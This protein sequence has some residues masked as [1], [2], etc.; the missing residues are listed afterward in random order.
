[1]KSSCMMSVVFGQVLERLPHKKEALLEVGRSFHRFSLRSKA[2]AA[3]SPCST[4]KASPADEAAAA[5]RTGFDCEVPLASQEPRGRPLKAAMAMAAALHAPLHDS[6]TT[7]R[8]FAG[9]TLTGHRG[10]GEGQLGPRFIYM[11]IRGR[12]PAD[13]LAWLLGALV[14]LSRTTLEK[15]AK[16]DH[17]CLCLPVAPSLL[18]TRRTASEGHANARMGF[19][20]P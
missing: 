10:G 17:V 20:L 13:G 3:S 4:R 11:R 7:A 8:C 5:Q 1:M 16:S 12:E 9:T 18:E 15:Q 19:R 6:L 14:G 2:Q